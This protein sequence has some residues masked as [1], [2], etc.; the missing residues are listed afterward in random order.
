M[1]KEALTALDSI[2]LAPPFTKRKA[3]HEWRPAV[4]GCLLVKRHHR[5]KMG[6]GGLKR[7]RNEKQDF[8][9]LV[10]RECSHCMPVLHR[11]SY[12]RLLYTLQIALD[13][14]SLQISDQV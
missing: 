14:K 1:K 4:T 3:L 10:N 6:A 8:P 9:L 13:I 7:E 2:H 11:M 5:K 12:V